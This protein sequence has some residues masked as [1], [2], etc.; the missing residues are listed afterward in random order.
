[1]L[2][3]L[4]WRTEK[5]TKTS[6]STLLSPPLLTSQPIATGFYFHYFL[7]IN[8]LNFP[9]TSFFPKSVEFFFYSSYLT[10]G[11]IRLWP[12]IFETLSL[13]WSR[14]GAVGG[15]GGAETSLCCILIYLLTVGD[16][17]FFSQKVANALW[18]ILE[19]SPI[20]VSCPISASFGWLLF[21]GWL[22]KCGSIEVHSL[23][24]SIFMCP[25]I[26]SQWLQ[27]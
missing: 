6:P 10:H 21:P 9:I 16:L 19:V 23:P 18:K 27:L 26:H 5:R 7:E 17:A 25:L 12:S 22:L 20:L 14:K 1:M 4:I 8:S 2:R 3:S 15:Y 24:C 11:N 13:V